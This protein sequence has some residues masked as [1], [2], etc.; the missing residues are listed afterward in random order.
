MKRRN[1]VV[2]M[3]VG[4][5]AMV[6]MPIAPCWAGWIH[7][8]TSTSSGSPNSD[9]DWGYGT[10]SGYW[11]AIWSWSYNV[12]GAS[13]GADSSGCYAQADMSYSA[14][15]FAQSWGGS[16]SASVPDGCWVAIYA[17]SY[18]ANIPEMGY[19]FLDYTLDA[20]VSGC[21]SV[22]GNCMPFNP[23]AGSAYGE[24]EAYGDADIGEN[25]VGGDDYGY[26]YVEGSFSSGSTGDTWWT[27]GGEAEEDSNPSVTESTGYYSITL[28]F[29]IYVSEG[30]ITLDSEDENCPSSYTAS[31]GIQAGSVD[32]YASVNINQGYYGES[33]AEAYSSMDGHSRVNVDLHN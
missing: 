25:T 11:Y 14:S 22:E 21:V 10:G 32:A 16:A 28:Y 5:V 1:Y 31:T 20:D 8:G 6:I 3:I 15:A 7:V 9:S 27:V 30:P 23:N 17:D 26:G 29:T 12:S 24:S 4:I 2:L 33:L 13:R 18:Y 19:R